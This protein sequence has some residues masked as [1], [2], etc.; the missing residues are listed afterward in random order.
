ME[1]GMHWLF[2]VN[3]GVIKFFP[4]PDEVQG[5][6]F[7]QCMEEIHLRCTYVVLFFVETAK[8]VNSQ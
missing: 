1:Y 7:S 5:R 3:E 8:N 2:V 6:A 4:F